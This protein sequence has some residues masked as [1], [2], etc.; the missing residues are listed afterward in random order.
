MPV[1]AGGLAVD[2]GFAFGGYFGG[3]EFVGLYFGVGTVSGVLFYGCLNVGFVVGQGARFEVGFL[4]V[5]EGG[6]AVEVLFD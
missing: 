4:G 3:F 2:F 6:I 5:A 1:F